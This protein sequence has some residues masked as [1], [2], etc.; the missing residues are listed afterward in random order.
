VGVVVLDGGDEAA[1]ALVA[2][3][4]IVVE[5]GEEVFPGLAMH[6]FSLNGFAGNGFA[7]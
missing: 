5:A 4:R 7:G 3:K 1:A 2:Y 6:A